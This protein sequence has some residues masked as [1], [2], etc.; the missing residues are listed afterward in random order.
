MKLDR[1]RRLRPGCAAPF[2][3]QTKGLRS[4]TNPRMRVDDNYPDAEGRNKMV[5]RSHA[6]L[7]VGTELISDVYL[8]RCRLLSHCDR[9]AGM[10]LKAANQGG[11]T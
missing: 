9:F 11:L 1:L 5:G 2:G 3:G 10:P 7:S 8:S 6:F 4:P